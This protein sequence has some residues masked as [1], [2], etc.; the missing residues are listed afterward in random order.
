LLYTA[1]NPFY[2]HNPIQNGYNQKSLAHTSTKPSI[3]EQKENFNWI[4]K[5]CIHVND[6][7]DGYINTLYHGILKKFIEDRRITTDI[8]IAYK[9]RF[10]D[11]IIIPIYEGGNI[12]YFQGRTINGNDIKYLNPVSDKQNIIFNK[13]NFIQ[14]KPI[15]ITEGI[16]DAMSISVNATTCL[17]KEISDEFL[18]KLYEYTDSIY[19]VLDNDEDGIS[20]LKKIIETSKYNQKLNYFIM[21]FNFDNHVDI[22]SI[23]MGNYDIDIENFI[24][25]NS[26]TIGVTT[27]VLNCQIILKKYLFF[28]YRMIY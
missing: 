16:I 20:S 21:P 28:L 2:T 18:S 19:I 14:N 15:F 26:Y 11:R 23:K 12:I 10:K 9:G 13:D 22:N 7:V 4:K 17:G 25:E 5:D 8:F 24:V 1:V 3:E 6:T 27:S